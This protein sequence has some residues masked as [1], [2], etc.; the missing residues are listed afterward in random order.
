MLDVDRTEI[1]D[2]I[3]EAE[4]LDRDPAALARVE[5]VNTEIYRRIRTR[6][7]EV[8]KLGNLPRLLTETLS[9]LGSAL[10]LTGRTA[11][12]HAVLSQAK[13]LSPTDARI[14]AQY[15][16]LNP[17]S[18]GNIRPSDQPLEVLLAEATV[19]HWKAVEVWINGCPKWVSLS[20][21]RSYFPVSDPAH[22]GDTFSRSILLLKDR[23][24]G[25]VLSFTN[26][27]EPLLPHGVVLTAVPP[28]EANQTESGVADLIRLLS[29]G[30]RVEGASVLRRTVTVPAQKFQDERN[31]D[32]HL[33]SICV[34][35]PILIQ[36]KSTLLLDDVITSGSSMVACARLLLQNGAS[37]VQCFA[38]GKTRRTVPQ[39]PWVRS[40]F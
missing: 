31:E 12:A 1:G 24:T 6:P 19:L 33:T 18:E 20:F 22:E 29:F 35:R 28:H 13:G 40:A 14:D 25:T 34:E 8:R 7:E 26:A 11:E 36:G 15:R 5:L 23:W 32:T 27:L 4:A 30:G 38:L 39:S 16:A 17:L 10:T 3:R 21:I 37:R 9:R 2:L